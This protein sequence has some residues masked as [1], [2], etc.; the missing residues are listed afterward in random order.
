MLGNVGAGSRAC[1]ERQPHHIPNGGGNMKRFFWPVCMICFL[2]S[3]SFVFLTGCDSGKKAVDEVTGNRALEQFEKA[4]KDVKAIE[5]KTK[6]RNKAALDD[7][8]QENEENK[9]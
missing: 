3:M 8:K 4:K 9:E 1:L 2:F 7:E 5:E 6:E